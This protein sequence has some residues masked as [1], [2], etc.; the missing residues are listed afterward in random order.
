MWL[1]KLEYNR[2]NGYE[3][4]IYKSNIVIDSLVSGFFK[5]LWIFILMQLLL[6]IVIIVFSI[7]NSLH[8]HVPEKNRQV[9]DRILPFQIN[10]FSTVKNLTFFLTPIEPMSDHIEIIYPVS[11]MRYELVL[12]MIFVNFERRQSNV[13]IKIRQFRMKLSH[14]NFYC[15]SSTLRNN[16]RKQ[17]HKIIFVNDCWVYFLIVILFDEFVTFLR[18]FDLYCLTLSLNFWVVDPIDCL[19]HFLHSAI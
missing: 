18:R 2:Q 12:A 8:S 10:R 16:I 13:L 6:I 9:A 1:G 3:Y 4:T 11:F 15:G 7:S 19:L 17:Y 5:V 14:M